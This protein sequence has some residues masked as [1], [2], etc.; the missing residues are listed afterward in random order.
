MAILTR[1]AVAVLLLLPPAVAS[2]EDHGSVTSYRPLGKGAVGMAVSGG[3][4]IALPMMA[5][6]VGF[7]VA[8]KL[9]AGVRYETVAGLLHFP[10]AGVRWVPLQWG[11]WYLGTKAGVAYS[12][13]GLQTED[14][15]LTSTLYLPFEIGL[16][17]AVTEHS[18]L[19]LAIGGELD[20]ARFVVIHDVGDG[21]SDVRYDATIFRFGLVSALTHDLDIFVQGRL[22]LPI[23]TITDGEHVFF[24][25]PFVEGGATWA[26]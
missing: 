13:F 2:A 3:Y 17:G 20:L 5:Y 8:D 22:R 21:A 1:L 26:F 15:N 4:A 12:F 25:V 14:L 24:V 6:E 18:D 23:E 7:G 19:V 10:S 16:S 11:D 9:D